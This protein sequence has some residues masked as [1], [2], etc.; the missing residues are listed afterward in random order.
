MPASGHIALRTRDEDGFV[1]LEVSDTG[2]GIPLALRERVFEPYFTTKAGVGTG[3]GL[4]TVF[5]IVA[6]HG[7]PS[8]RSTTSRAA[9]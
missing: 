3:L 5:G 2:S 9:R 6:S 4:A 7:G 1:V 8:S